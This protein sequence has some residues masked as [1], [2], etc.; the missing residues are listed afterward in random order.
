MLRSTCA[1]LAL[2]V[3]LSAAAYAQDE[4]NAVAAVFDQEAPGL[5]ETNSGR[6]RILYNGYFLAFRVMKADVTADVGDGEYAAS[7]VFRTAGIAGWFDDSEIEARTYGALNGQGV[8]PRRYQHTNHASSKN[9]I[10]A[11]DFQDD[12]TVPVVTPEFGSPG[13]PAPTPDDLFG[14]LDP[15]STFVTIALDGGDQPCN[16]TVEVFD[17]KQRFDLTLR[18]VETERVFTRAYDGDALH[19][20]VFYTPVAGFDPEDLADPEDY[21][22]PMSIWLAEFGDGRWAPVRIHARVSGVT[23]RIE[24]KSVQVEASAIPRRAEIE[25][26]VAE[27]TGIDHG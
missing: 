25:T 7:A 15:I 27:D 26:P 21:A 1:A 4:V 16:R 5:D 23:A 13:D 22:R 6:L 17:G 2:A 3:G 14:S 10:V 18:A 11:I 20:H 24:A 12:A 8:E 19:C 9:R